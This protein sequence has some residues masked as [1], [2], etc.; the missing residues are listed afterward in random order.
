[1]AG[2]A[3][4][5][6]RRLTPNDIFFVYADARGAYWHSGIF[7]VAWAAGFAQRIDLGLA[8]Q[9]A[10]DCWRVDLL[11]DFA[12]KECRGMRNGKLRLT[13]LV[14]S[15]LALV[16]ATGAQ[17]VAVT[18]DDLPSHG[19]L[20]PAMTRVDVANSI[21]KTLKDYR[22]PKVYGFVNAKKLETHPDE[23]AVLKLWRAAG[24]PL[25]NH[26]YAHLSL[27]AS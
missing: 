27:N 2:W 12:R 26:T 23:I 24:Y 1:M 15:S 11:G 4:H 18:V 8:A 6:S 25:G 9:C 5:F 14:I 3:S 17:E 19:A 13:I 7:L 10:A 22:A 20:P 21:L 16:H